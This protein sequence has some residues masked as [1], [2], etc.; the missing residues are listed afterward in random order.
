[1][2]HFVDDAGRYALFHSIAFIAKAS[3]VRTAMGSS[4]WG[5][6]VEALAEIC[7]SSN[8]LVP[9]RL[10]SGW[11]AG[12]FLSRAVDVVAGL[13]PVAGSSHNRP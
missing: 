11:F 13:S 7:S 4:A 12:S 2:T 6:Y 10:V 5:D 8:E 1:M 9:A 3:V